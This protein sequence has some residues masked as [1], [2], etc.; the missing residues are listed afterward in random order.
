MKEIQLLSWN[1]LS[2]EDQEYARKYY[3]AIIHYSKE[4]HVDPPE[5]DAVEFC[6]FY[7]DD[8]GMIEILG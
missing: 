7:Y 4:F 6:Q 3:E 8:S 1:D 5:S 2:P